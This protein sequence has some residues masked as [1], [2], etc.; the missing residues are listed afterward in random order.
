MSLKLRFFLLSALLLLIS[1]IAVWSSVK[2]LAEQIIEEW[3]LRYAEKQVL[4]DRERTLQPIMRE[5]ALALQFAKSSSLV[6]YARNPD[7]GTLRR[8][9]LQEMENFRFNFVEMNYFVALKKSGEYFHNDANNSYAGQ[10]LRYRLDENSPKDAWFFRVLKQ[11]LELHINVNLDSELGVTKLWINALLN[12]GGEPLGVVG[13][14][15]NLS[16]FLNQIVNNTDEGVTNLFV[17]QTASVQLHPQRTRIS[18]SSISAPKAHQ[19]YIYQYLDNDSDHKRV[20]LI[21][22]EA[23]K[24]RDKVIS[25]FV[26]SEGRRQL[27]AVAYIPELNWYEITFIDIAKL[28]P[29]SRFGG[30]FLVYTLTIIALII[31]FNLLLQRMVLRPVQRLNTAITQVQAAKP[32][33]VD[34]RGK[35]EVGD[36]IRHFSEMADAV[37][38]YRTELE[39]KVKARTQALEAQSRTDTLTQLYN[40]GGMTERLNQVFNDQAHNIGFIWIDLDYFKEI[41]DQY[42]HAC[43]D[44]ALV[45]VARIIEQQI[46][47]ETGVSGFSGRWGGDEF[48]ACVPECDH[49]RLSALSETICRTVA[50]FRLDYHP[51]PDRTQSQQ[52]QKQETDFAG[53]EPLPLTVSIGTYLSRQG[54]NLEQALHCADNAL[55]QAKDDGRNCVR[56]FL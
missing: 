4:Y 29:L 43:G 31:L 53:R 51:H 47:Q 7:D 34:L 52:P 16:H 22:T 33:T 40:R 37:D 56:Q 45:A 20:D 32:V 21:M 38:Q 12:D 42:G 48:L 15:L 3:A 2:T 30:I 11:Q 26:V 46:E 1:S 27:M 39:N 54:D 8:A 6:A 49:A 41:N 44:R 50:G 5:I 25:E 24:Q 28:L 13:T 18:F 17:D 36:L 23:R 9:A 10:Q 19:Q 55:Y 35:G 14:G